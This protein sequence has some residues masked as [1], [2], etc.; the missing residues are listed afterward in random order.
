MDKPILVS[1]CDYCKKPFIYA[2]RSEMGEE[3]NGVWAHATCHDEVGDVG[4][5]GRGSL[6]S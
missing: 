4:A 6:L 2:S 1:R 3:R 5:Q